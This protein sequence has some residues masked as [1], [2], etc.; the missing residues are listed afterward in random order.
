MN[1][2]KASTFFL[3]MFVPKWTPTRLMAELD[4]RNCARN[5]WFCLPREDGLRDKGRVSIVS[6]A[7]MAPSPEPSAQALGG[8]IMMPISSAPR[9]SHS[10]SPSS[11]RV[12]RL[13]GL[14]PKRDFES[15]AVDFIVSIDVAGAQDCYFNA[16]GACPKISSITLHIRDPNPFSNNCFIMQLTFWVVNFR[17]V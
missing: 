7:L 2:F 10:I 16:L 3:V 4:K 11:H 8:H 5:L 14:A 1:P 15:T 6:F 17:I 12:T 13:A 9:R